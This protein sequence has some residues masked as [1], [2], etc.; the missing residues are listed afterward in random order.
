MEFVIGAFL[1]KSAEK[2]NFDYNLTRIVGTLHEDK[3]TFF[4]YLA[5]FFLE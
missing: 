4:L 5:H 3:Y 2:F 1:E